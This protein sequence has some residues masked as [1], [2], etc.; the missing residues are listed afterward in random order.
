VQAALAADLELAT[1]PALQTDG[2]P[3]KILVTA[4]M[5]HE[6]RNRNGAVFVREELPAAAAKI[7]A[8]NVL[9]MDWDH[10][11]FLP[12]ADG[13]KAM[14]VWLSADYAFDQKAQDGQGAW[15][16]LVYGVVWAWAFPDQANEM[17]ADQSRN[18]EVSF[19]MACVPSSVEFGHD[20][21][22]SFEVLHNPVFYTVSALSGRPADPDAVGRIEEGGNSM[23]AF[24]DLRTELTGRQLIAARLKEGA[25]DE[26]KA[27]LEALKE[28]LAAMQSDA[29]KVAELTAKVVALE[30]THAELTS[31]VTE[32]DVA[33]AALTAKL[34]ET[35]AALATLTAERD[36]L[37]EKV[38]AFAEAEAEAARKA[39]F[40]ERYASIPEAYRT[41]LEK[42]PEADRA[43][44]AER[45]TKAS[46]AEWEQF[47]EDV[48]VG[49]EG[50]K[51][52]FLDRSNAEGGLIPTA[53]DS[54][55]AA[56]IAGLLK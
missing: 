6:G 54:D 8:P 25:M 11:A 39:V 41:Q 45:W 29:A 4:W 27:E 21:L 49:F 38:A 12:F 44:F 47:K 52:S 35:D 19:S 31:Q 22:G 9:P 43:K 28:Q 37:A 55:L 24:S 32:R 51:L 23:Q 18:S 34:S 40:V 26:L 30:S 48:L 20:A 14:G 36:A 56:G 17:L 42:R 13:P 3:T 53:M 15:G 2:E 7:K 16:I 5:A 33:V 50:L 1:R 46:D 10:A